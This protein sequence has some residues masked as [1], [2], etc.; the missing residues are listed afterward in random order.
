M[1]LY[2]Y[3]HTNQYKYKIEYYLNQ[4]THE[5]WFGDIN[6]LNYIQVCDKSTKTFLP[7]KE[8]DQVKNKFRE[9]IDTKTLHQYYKPEILEYFLLYNKETLVKSVKDFQ[10]RFGLKIKKLKCFCNTNEHTI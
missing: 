5:V 1:K 3:K 4:T 6:K 9:N 8:Q 10:I 7:K 2:I